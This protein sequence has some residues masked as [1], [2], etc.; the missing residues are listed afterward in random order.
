MR[1][2]M[3]LYR[4]DQALVL[5]RNALESHADA[6]LMSLLAKCHMAAGEEMKAMALLEKCL[7]QNPHDTDLFVELFESTAG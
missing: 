3:A 5:G 7:E 4:H 6:R 1:A 2:H